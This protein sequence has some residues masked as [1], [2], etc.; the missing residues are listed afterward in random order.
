MLAL[1]GLNTLNKRDFKHHDGV[2]M[3]CISRGI[4]TVFIFALVA[5]AAPGG[6]MADPLEFV[7]DLFSSD[8][9]KPQQKSAVNAAA[10]CIAGAILAKS[11]NGNIGSGCLEGAEK[12]MARER[13]EKLAAM[14]REAQK[15]RVAQEKSVAELNRQA[16][17]RQGSV[18]QLLAKEER[19]ETGTVTKIKR[20]AAPR[21]FPEVKKE[22]AAIDADIAK[23]ETLAKDTR[24][25]IKE[26]ETIIHGTTDVEAQ[27]IL[28]KEISNLYAVLKQT[29]YLMVANTTLKR[30]LDHGEPGLWALFL[31]FLMSVGAFLRG[32]IIDEIYK[33]GRETFGSKI[34][35]VVKKPFTRKADPAGT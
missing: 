9:G 1:A 29:E 27:L 35:I 20:W 15:N 17:E 4:A 5:F 2:G 23:S 30:D 14:E 12:N 25:Q 7:K 24:K 11:A 22:M 13:E 32:K 34:M 6:A 21:S 8:S 28:A 31:G 16:A 3:V 26:K 10:G 18:I 33:K 19:A